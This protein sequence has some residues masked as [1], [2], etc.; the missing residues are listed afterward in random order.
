MQRLYVLLGATGVGKTALSIKFAEHFGSPII[1]AD[2][3]QIYREMSIGT[4][5]PSNEELAAVKHYFIQTRSITEYY[6]ASAYEDEAISLISNLHKTNENLILC[7]GSMLYI[8]AVCNGIDEMPTVMPEIRQAL[9]QQFEIEGLMPL[10]EELRQRDPHHYEAVD[11]Q[12]HRRVIHALEICR[13]T[14]KP[15]SSFRTQTRKSR[16]FEIIKIGLTRERAD[17]YAR[18]DA[19]V[20]RMIRDGLVEEARC[21][22][23]MRH[24][25]ALNTVGYKELF[26]YFDGITTKEEAIA[27]IKFN[28]HLY[29]RKQ[30]TWF[31]RDKSIQWFHPDNTNIF[32]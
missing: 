27:K 20:D 3:R 19:R 22:Y 26:A 18:I 23:P 13:M 30:T 25:N 29:A 17:L 7:G 5:V 12:N 28:T 14:G 6:S 1:S 8:D 32:C 21:L 24:L 31:R 11:R 15:Y 2:S 4:A 16:P 10:L 9:W